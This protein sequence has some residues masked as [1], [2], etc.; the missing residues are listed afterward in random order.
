LNNYSFKWTNFL[1]YYQVINAIPKRLLNEAKKMGHKLKK[2]LYFNNA[3]V[4]Q[5]NESSQTNLTKT[6][7]SDFYKL[8]NTKTYTAGQPLFNKG[9]GV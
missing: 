1:Q 9:R 4:F 2:E 5:L 6:R 3:F 8:F 7:T